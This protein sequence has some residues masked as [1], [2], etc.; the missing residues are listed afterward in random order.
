MLAAPAAAGGIDFSPVTDPIGQFVQS[1]PFLEGAGLI[2]ADFDGNVLHEQ[3][4]GSYDRST[5]L[6]MASASKWMSAAAVMSLVDDGLADLDTPLDQYLPQFAGFDDGRGDVTLRQM[7][8]HTSGMIGESP[9]VNDRTLTLEEAVDAIAITQNLMTS[10]PGERFNYGGVSMHV[11]GRVAE[12]TA[13]M[14]WSTLVNERLGAMLDVDD[15]SWAGLGATT[16][17]RPAASIETSA[18]TYLDFLLSMVNGGG[19]LLSP[20]AAT[21]MLS[22]QAEDATVGFT[23]PSLDEFLGYGLGSWILRRGNDGSPAVFSS[24][25]AF[26]TSPWVDLENEYVGIFVIRNSNISVTPLVEDVRDFAEARV[27]AAP[28]LAGDADRD[29]DVDLADFTLLRNNF[30]TVPGRFVGGDLD[31]NA[32]VDLA[33]FTILRNHFGEVLELPLL[34]TWYA[35]TVPEPI[36]GVAA[37]V[38]LVAMRRQR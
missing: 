23:P 34:D 10:Q 15:I 30:G 3:Y 5:T 2:L 31:G 19:A 14:D 8:S 29:G 20:E 32:I 4:W 1:R 22:D 28:S 18:A 16:N 13:G 6:P 21:I 38:G 36:V 11:G 9:F 27:N 33:D 12:V 35:A 26:G 17:P 24:P 37:T 7:F 25:G